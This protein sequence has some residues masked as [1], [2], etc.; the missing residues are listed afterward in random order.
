MFYMTLTMYTLQVA[1]VVHCA[2]NAYLMTFFGTGPIG[3]LLAMFF[4]IHCAQR[5]LSVRKYISVD[6]FGFFLVTLFIFA[7][8]SLTDSLFGILLTPAMCFI[9]IAFTPPIVYRPQRFSSSS[10]YSQDS[11]SQDSIPIVD[12]ASTSF[13][14]PI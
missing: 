5:V 6:Y 3:F 11:R 9:F 13:K 10:P 14:R 8:N 4:F 12:R 2:H 7:M 1:H